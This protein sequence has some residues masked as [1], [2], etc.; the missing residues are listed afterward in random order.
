MHLGHSAIGYVQSHDKEY[1]RTIPKYYLRKKLHQPKLQ[2]IHHD[3]YR[4]LQVRGLSEEKLECKQ[5]TRILDG[6]PGAFILFTAESSPV[7]RE[8]SAV[9]DSTLPNCDS[10]S[11]TIVSTEKLRAKRC[12]EKVLGIRTKRCFPRRKRVTELVDRAAG[13]DAA[14]AHGRSRTFS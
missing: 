7:C 9:L 12:F 13:E 6:L 11:E 5:I 3:T 1:H 8:D 4:Q 14:S 10:A 2:L